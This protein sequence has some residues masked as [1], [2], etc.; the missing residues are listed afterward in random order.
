[1]TKLIWDYIKANNLQKEGDRRVIVCDARMLKVFKIPEFTMFEM[2]KY[3][4]EVR[5]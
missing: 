1:V 5:N 3:V 2:T 4:N